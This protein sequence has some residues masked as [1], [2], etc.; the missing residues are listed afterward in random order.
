M[1]QQLSWWDISCENCVSNCT[2]K[3][4]LNS[5]TPP[6]EDYVPGGCLSSNCFLGGKKF[7]GGINAK[8]M[9]SQ[10]G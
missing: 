5:H 10:G 9:V 4:P 2:C 1:Y 3:L 7:K 6:A 8:L